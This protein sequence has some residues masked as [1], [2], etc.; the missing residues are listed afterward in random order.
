MLRVGEITIEE[1]DLPSL[2]SDDVVRLNAFT[3]ELRAEA[4][5]DDPP[6]PIDYTRASV[7]NIP[8]F[9]AVREFWARD[10]DG[11]I[12]GSAETSFMRTEENR[13]LLEVDLE[14]HP[15][16]RRQGLAKALLGLVVDVAAEEGRTLL[17]GSTSERVPAGEAFA[18]R[19]GAERGIANH[20]NRLMTASVDRDLM[21]RWVEE[22][23]ERAPDYELFVVDGR[24]P[25]ELVEAIC[26]LAEVMNTA[27]M[28]DLEVEDQRFT[29]EQARQIERVLDA[30][31]SERW[32]LFIR[33]VPTGGL[34]GYTQVFWSP[35]QPRTIWQGDTGVRP[36]HRGHA[37]GKWL[38][39]AMMERILDERPDVKDVRTGNADSNAPML[40]INRAMGFEP[41][42]A[43]TVWQVRLD[44]VRAYL[45]G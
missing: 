3:N 24:Y 40:G 7:R 39:A 20:V 25:D 6:Q 8:G 10:P 1:V 43:T 29:V 5:P 30:R 13:H 37:L 41:Y 36:E 45:K 2:S 18:R 28:D 33:H 22:G 26:D 44:R 35:S 31:G 19:L 32:S 11:S 4:H 27:P 23:P 14:V 21:H 12:A 15:D 38:K 34:A 17:I 16:R 42:E 9:V